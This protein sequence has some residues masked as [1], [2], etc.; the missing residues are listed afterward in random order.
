MLSMSAATEQKKW[1][2]ILPLVTFAYYTAKHEKTGFMPFFYF[3]DVNLKQFSMQCY[4]A[5]PIVLM[6]TL[7]K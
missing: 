6:I 1:D 3:M 7:P 4:P 5:V 2:K